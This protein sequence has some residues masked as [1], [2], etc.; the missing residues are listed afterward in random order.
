MGQTD[1][2]FLRACWREP[3]DRTPVWFMRQAGRYMA[4]YRAIRARHTLLEICARPELA[5]E[6][7]LQPVNRLDVDAAIIFAD[8]LL[9]LV[10]MGIELE[11]A[12][13]EGP[14]IHNPVRAAADVDALRV[15]DPEESISNTLDAIRIVAHELDGKVPLI[16]FAGGPFTVASYL[17]EGGSSRSYIRTKRLMYD[18]PDAWAK[19]M[20]KLAA[21]T[22]RYLQAQIKAGARAV[23]LFDSWVGALSPYDYRTR[24]LP[25]MRGIIEQLTPLGVP[26]ILFG[27]G[28]S[29]ILELLAAAGSDVVGVD[30]RI[31]ID[32]AW[33]RIGTDRA[34]QGNLDPVALFAP[35]DE[36]ERQVRDI[37]DRADNRPGHI[38]NLGHGI[39]PETP[40]ENV[41]RVIELVHRL[42][43][44]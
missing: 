6:V 31:N 3:V 40:V 4:E 15:I 7:T 14:V 8:I 16:G 38:F 13:G 35:A 37:L 25:Y 26:V 36:I 28:T 1:S 17:T 39:L 2:R 23:Q 34:V 10:P 30:W 33:A 27:T 11:F 24:V 21:V 19:L 43:E 44:R 18:A 22:T 41:Q 9:P 29:G 5:A 32:E 42:S 20:E 12:A